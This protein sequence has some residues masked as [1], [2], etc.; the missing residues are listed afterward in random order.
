MPKV[1]PGYKEEVRRIIIEAA[2]AESNENG[3]SNVKMDNIAKRLGISRTT[4][5][6]YFKNREEILDAAIEYIREEL[7]V[8]LREAFLK[9]D[10]EASL[11]AIYDFFVQNEDEPEMNAIIGV[12]A[13]SVYDEKTAG[14]LRKNF[15]SMH[16]LIQAAIDDQIKKGRISGDLNSDITAYT[17]QALSL[18]IKMTLV[19][20]LE[21]E[22]AKEIWKSAL[23]K[24]LV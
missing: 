15:I 17:I 3:F 14:V 24:L 6:I 19:G 1:V 16:D 21:R 5:Y 11:N 22:T 23:R 2:I 18:G 20:G 13:R 7:S 12:F 8:V 4:I 9:D 10:L